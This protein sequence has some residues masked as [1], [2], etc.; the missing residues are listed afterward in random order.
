M[1]DRT[2]ILVDMNA[3]FANVE[4][5]CNPALRGKPV[6]VGGS[7][8]K[9]SVVAAASYEARPYGIHSG[10]ATF[11]AI[12]KCPDAIIVT[13]DTTKYS[14]TARR[15]FDIC[16]DY[17]DL[18]EIY[19]IDECFLDVTHTQE[20]FGGAWKIGRAIKRR[21]RAEFGL[22]CSVGIAPN[23]MLAK[24]AANIQK[25]DGLVE[26]K[27][28]DVKNLLE[29]LPV[30][31][32]HG[33]GERLRLQLEKMG[34]TTAGQLGRTPKNILK[35]KFGVLG[36]ALHGMGNG[37]YN[38]AIIPYYGKPD[39]KSVSHSYTLSRNTRD[40]DLVARHLLRL[41]EM[42]G[43]RLR[44]Q[45]F[46]GKTVTLVIRYADMHFAGY[47]KTFSRYFDDG[48]DIYQAAMSI[49]DQHSD[50]RAIR[51]VGVCVSSL[52]KNAH[53]MNLFT[54]PRGQNLLKALD[55]INDRYGEFA[56]KRAS[57]VGIKALEKVHGFDKKKFS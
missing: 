2:I 7:L 8:A 36:E 25:P 57:L 13:G 40:L 44:E 6:L 19:S 41:S 45:G 52:A 38:P 51:L 27:H 10:M 17:T 39:I 20:R 42:V 11:Q 16:G 23:I 53:Q 4:Q 56:I 55:A 33:I 30:E 9:R 21:I 48:F 1:T 3:F 24:L 37:I 46:A 43:R 35:L 14:D 29:S 49:F 54:D 12:E 18:M 15:I 22:T 5:R 31:K 26:I 32:L 34:I 47:R 50:R 28:E